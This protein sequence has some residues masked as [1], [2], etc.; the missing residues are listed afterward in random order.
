M[1]EEEL[2]M[3]AKA[4]LDPQNGLLASL[5]PD[6]LAVLAP[7]LEP[8]SLMQRDILFEPSSR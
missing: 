5:S 6:D 1:Y 4:K 8:V 7:L 3:S 2:L